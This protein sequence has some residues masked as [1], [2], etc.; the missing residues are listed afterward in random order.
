MKK[1][2]WIVL[3]VL[4]LVVIV[5]AFLMNKKSAT[6]GAANLTQNLIG[7]SA[8]TKTLPSVLVFENNTSTNPAIDGG[9]IQQSLNTEGY[10]NVR[11]DILAIG[12]TATSTMTIRQQISQD[13]TNWFS[14]HATSTSQLSQAGTSTAMMVPLAVAIVPGAAS[15]TMSFT[16]NTFSARFNR[17]LFLQDDLASDSTDGVKA[18]VQSVL[19]EPLIKL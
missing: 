9:D 7:S 14:V 6:F 5:G 2:I 10:S 3:G 13:N 12:K 16:F 15:S 1:N 8:V 4:V 19:I 17:F 18:W 11:L